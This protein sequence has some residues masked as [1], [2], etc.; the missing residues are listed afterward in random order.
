MQVRLDA[1]DLVQETF[2]KAHREFGQFLGP[3]EPELAAWLRQILVRTLANQA[4]HHRPKGRDYRGRIAGSLARSLEL[5]SAAR[6]PRDFVAESA[7]R[8][9]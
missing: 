9:A 7:R 2:L 1:S 3:S 5:G 8:P 4:R 6:W